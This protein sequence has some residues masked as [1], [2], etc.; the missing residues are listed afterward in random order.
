[1]TGST[2]NLHA[3]NL[4][5]G[6]WSGLAGGI[7]LCL[8]AATALANT[9]LGNVQAEKNLKDIDP[10]VRERAAQELGEGGNPAYVTE[11]LVGGHAHYLR[12]WLSEAIRIGPLVPLG[13]CT[14]D[15]SF[16]D[17]PDQEVDYYRLRVAQ[18]NNQWAWLSPIW[19]ER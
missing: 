11:L 4:H 16:D 2:I 3:G 6:K 1:M 15:A 19:A 8:L 18:H 12:G 13:R 9:A 10:K 14:V 5:A 17:D 7:L